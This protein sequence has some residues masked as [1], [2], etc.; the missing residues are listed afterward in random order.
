VSE[1]RLGVIGMGVMGCAHA[2]WIASPDVNGCTLAAVQDIDTSRCAEFEGA[3][4][5]SNADEMI[6]S[7]LVDGVVIATPHYFHTT[8]GIAALEAGLHV[9]VEKPISVHKADAERLVAAR[10]DKSQVFAAM[11][12]L[13]TLPSSQK[14]HKLI[15]RGELGKIHRIQWSVTRCFRSEAYYRS[16]S[17]RATWEGEGGGVLMNQAPHMLDMFQW[18]F[19]MPARLRAF[20]GFGH[21]HDIEVE[22]DV[23]A[24][25]EFEEGTKAV[26]VASTGEAPGL[27]RLEVSSDMGLLVLDGATELTFIRNEE[28]ITE[29]NKTTEKL[30]G[31]PPTWKIEIPLQKPSNTYVPMLQNFVDAI[32]EGAPLIAPAEQGIHSVELA[33]AMVYS[34]IKEQTVELPLDGAAYEAELQR[35]IE[36]SRKSGRGG[37]RVH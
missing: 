25:M 2:R 20:C 33:N 31:G 26:I 37:D 17:W 5:F 13:R 1:V 10:K 22:D 18:W 14:V 12:N 28:P 9:M 16:G 15:Q 19:G 6:R 35:L 24:Y 21:F 30:M 3:A 4:H 7:G 27:D 11:F 36:E 34:S 29:F 8:I 32:R 23:T